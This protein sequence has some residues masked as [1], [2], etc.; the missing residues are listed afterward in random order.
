MC[1]STFISNQF[2]IN[3]KIGWGAEDD[4]MYYRLELS[5]VYF[6]RPAYNTKYSMLKHLTRWA[7]PKRYEILMT[8]KNQYKNDGLTTAKYTNLGSVKYSLFTHLLVDVGVPTNIS[9]LG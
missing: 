6:D 1:N 5:G 9:Y 7:N 3:T 8:N 2:A 4:D